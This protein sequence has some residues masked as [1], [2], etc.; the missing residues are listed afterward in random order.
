MP[1]VSPQMRQEIKADMNRIRIGKI[2]SLDG[3]KYVVVSIEDEE[4]VLVCKLRRRHPNRN[5]PDLR[6]ELYY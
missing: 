4:T 6:M 2:I 1:N 5:E 3:I